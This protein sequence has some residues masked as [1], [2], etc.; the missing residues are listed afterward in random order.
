MRKW[1]LSVAACGLVALISQP[2]QAT[3]VTFSSNGNFANPTNCTGVFSPACT[4]ANGGNTLILGT[5]A[6]GGGAQS[7]LKAIDLS[8]TTTST[9]QNDFKIGEIDWVNN[10]TTN[11]DS[12]FNDNYTLT[13]SFTAP[14]V[15]TQ[16]ALIALNIQ[17]PTNPPG[18]SVTNLVLSALSPLD[19]SFSGLTVSD[20]KFSLGSAGSGSTFNSTTGAW[21][22]PE[23]NTAKLF[24]TAD[25][26]DTG[27]PSQTSAVPEPMS[28]V[29]FG[30]GL[31]GL[32]LIRRSRRV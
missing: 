19:V 8:S 14:G 12:N 16:T 23:N 32:G 18:D 2:S 4:T 25:F 7:T 5:G 6:F 30:S 15:S 20:V 21:F 26:T 29:L 27:S 10:P 3:T 24:I 17:Q 31:V 13:M 22:N 1:V 9:P 28:L 11:T